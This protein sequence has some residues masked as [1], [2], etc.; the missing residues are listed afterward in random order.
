[1]TSSSPDRLLNTEGQPSGFWTPSPDTKALLLGNFSPTPPSFGAQAAVGKTAAV[2]QREAAG[3]DIQWGG[4]PGPRSVGQDHGQ[5]H[6]LRPAWC[7]QGSP[8]PCARSVPR[9]CAFRRHLP[10]IQWWP[11][12]PASPLRRLGTE[13]QT[14]R[15]P[16]F[17]AV[18]AS[19]SH[20]FPHPCAVAASRD[21]HCFIPSG[22]GFFS[23]CSSPAPMPSHSNQ[24]EA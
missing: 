7:L 15:S 19:R 18:G 21:Y 4:R 9:V 20:P 22:S 17:V 24:T 5:R 3:T 12:N 14:A 6:R 2:F 1:M 23:A 8:G 11:S 10:T 16:V 13:A